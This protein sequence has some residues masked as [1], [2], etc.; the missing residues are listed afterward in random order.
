MALQANPVGG[1]TIKFDEI[2]DV[3]EWNAT[4]T[5]PE[6]SPYVNGQFVLKFH[7]S[8]N[9][10][11]FPPTV[12]FVTPTYHPNINKDTG[13]ICLSMLK[14]QS[15]CDPGEQGWRSDFNIR[16]SKFSNL[17]HNLSFCFFQSFLP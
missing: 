14:P 9:Y 4:I 8:G 17:F 11:Q 5:G 3:S 16:H 12:M 2:T 15:D 1:C 7:F 10:P 6:G 13:S